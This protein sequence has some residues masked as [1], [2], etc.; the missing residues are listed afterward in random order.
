MLLQQL[1][2]RTHLVQAKLSAIIHIKVS[3]LPQQNIMQHS[4]AGGQA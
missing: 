4:Q 2:D 3:Y 1:P